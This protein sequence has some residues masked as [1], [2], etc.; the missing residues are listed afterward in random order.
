MCSVSLS[1]SKYHLIYKKNNLK[2]TD[3]TFFFLF[4]TFVYSSHCLTVY[5][6]HS[7]I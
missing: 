2:V 6:I 5:L 1:R 7:V 3:S 4:D